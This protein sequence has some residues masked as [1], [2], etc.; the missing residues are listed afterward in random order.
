MTAH[1]GVIIVTYNSS[2]DIL[3]CLNSIV[4]ATDV[5]LDIIVIDN[6]SSDT[7]CQLVEQWAPP[8]NTALTLLKSPKNGGFAAGVNIGL[9]RLLSRPH[10]DR[11]WILNPDSISTPKTPTA[12][13]KFPTPFSL[14]GCRITYAAPADQI[15]ID[16]GTVNRWTGATGNINLGKLAQ[17]TPTPNPA[18]FD[19]I[20]GA[21]MV[22]SR[23]FVEATGPMPEDYFLYYEE[24]DWAA[25]RGPLPLAY[26]EDAHVVHSAGAS[27][28]SATLARGPS[29]V[30]VYFKHRA[31]LRF[32][33]RY[34]P[35]A[36]PCAYVFGWAKIVQNLRRGQGRAA[37]SAARAIH[38][39]PPNSTVKSAISASPQASANSLTAEIK[40]S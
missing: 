8:P 18:T 38:G 28:G 22:A 1:L 12:L 37:L 5:T 20:S 19:F 16:A 9:E 26:C 7:T 23:E 6:A 2:A 14:L 25:R 40:L 36:L 39:L 32:I 34:N 3:N 13:A 10:L 11:F 30:S 4:A 29:E 31:R 24:V 17:D 21:S 15:Q 35:I 33:A 27:I